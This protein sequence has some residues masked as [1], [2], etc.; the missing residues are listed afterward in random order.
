MHDLRHGSDVV[1]FQL[2]SSQHLVELGRWCRQPAL[3]G[4]KFEVPVEQRV[5]QL[6]FH[7][8]GDRAQQYSLLGLHLEHLCC[9]TLTLRTAVEGEEHVDEEMLLHGLAQPLFTVHGYRILPDLVDR[10]HAPRR[11][12]VGVHPLGVEVHLPHHLL[13]DREGGPYRC[14]PGFQRGLGDLVG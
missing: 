14:M 13:R 7:T 9:S 1:D 8:R 2:C 6:G 12:N 10:V 3:G 4:C 11:V 5:E